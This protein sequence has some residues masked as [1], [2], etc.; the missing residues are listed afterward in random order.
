M[1]NT[2]TH[3]IYPR[4]FGVVP[5]KLLIIIPDFQDRPSWGEDPPNRRVTVVTITEM[6]R[7]VVW[8]QGNPKEGWSCVGSWLVTMVAKRNQHITWQLLLGQPR[9]AEEQSE[10]QSWAQPTGRSDMLLAECVGNLESLYWKQ[11]SFVCVSI[12]CLE[13][14]A[15]G[16]LTNRVYWT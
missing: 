16:Y 14:Q 5:T 9:S 15:V 3:E 11:A 1:K 4:M 7:N 8:G 6:Y 2:F 12:L 13:G 10:H